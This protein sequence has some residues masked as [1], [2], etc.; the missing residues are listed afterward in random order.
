MEKETI[1]ICRNTEELASTFAGMLSSGIK[2]LADGH[3]FSLALSGGSTPKAIFQHLAADI[4]RDIDWSRITIF[5]GD[6]RCVGPDSD[7]SN[8][9]MAKENLL[10]LVPIPDSNIFRIMGE[11]DPSTEAKRY[12]DVIRRHLPD[13]NGVPNFHLIMLGLGDDGHTASI[14]PDQIRL[15]GS[16]SLCVP[17]AN[18]YSGQKRVSVTGKLINHADI[19]VF[20]ATG[21]SKAEKV[22][23][24]IQKREGWEML[25]AALVEPEH[26]ELIWLLD[27]P[28]AG[29]LD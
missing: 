29:K 10:D 28:A 4:G 18:P 16:S 11:N 5:W 3:H 12:E 26:G 2:N 15:F 17:A 8:Y 24:V 21:P 1:K 19:V 7:E 20:L 13:Y 6:E 22:A 27:G 23:Q 25:P 14:F 9:K